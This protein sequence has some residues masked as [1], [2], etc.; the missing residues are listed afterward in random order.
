MALYQYTNR[1]RA[2]DDV[3]HLVNTRGDDDIT[4]FVQQGMVY[5]ETGT[6]VNSDQIMYWGNRMNQGIDEV[7][8]LEEVTELYHGS[9]INRFRA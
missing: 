2:K 7:R 1:R 8:D 9:G 4:I 6:Y 3:L 5:V